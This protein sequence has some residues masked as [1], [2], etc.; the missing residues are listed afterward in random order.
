MLE[1]C[2]R[3]VLA[4]SAFGGSLESG[5]RFYVGAFE[6]ETMSLMCGHQRAYCLSPLITQ[7]I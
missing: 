6:G 4:Q 2:L 1:W 3:W 7:V 5:G